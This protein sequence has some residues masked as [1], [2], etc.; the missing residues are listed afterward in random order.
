MNKLVEIM[1]IPSLKA[2]LEWPLSEVRY[3]LGL[4]KKRGGQ[5][6]N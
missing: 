2:V 5:I 4:I 1:Y 6:W 3:G